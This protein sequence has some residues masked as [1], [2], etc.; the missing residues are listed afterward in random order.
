MP[1]MRA[2]ATGL[3]DGDLARDV[4]TVDGAHLRDAADR[5]DA[6][7]PAHGTKFFADITL[8]VFASST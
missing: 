2:L 7:G 1:G 4:V 5:V 3:H 6:G 8:P